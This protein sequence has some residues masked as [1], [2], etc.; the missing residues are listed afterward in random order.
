MVAV[1]IRK[2]DAYAK[3]E[4]EFRLESLDGWHPEAFDLEAVRRRFDL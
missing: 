4:V 2:L 1:S 3:E